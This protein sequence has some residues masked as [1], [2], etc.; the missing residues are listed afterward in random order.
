[1]ARISPF[2]VLALAAALLAAAVAAQQPS[3]AVGGAA[4][5]NETDSCPF[6]YPRVAIADVRAGRAA[7]Y[8]FGGIFDRPS[9]VNC[10]RGSLFPTFCGFKLNATRLHFWDEQ[11]CAAET[12]SRAVHYAAKWER[13]A[14]Q[15]TPCDLFQ[16]LKGR[17]LWIIG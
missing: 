1:M 7:P 15:L 9:C 5:A 3:T 2:R 4:A 16:Y 12:A 14:L 13:D 10:K 6:S 17:T 11:I 8:L